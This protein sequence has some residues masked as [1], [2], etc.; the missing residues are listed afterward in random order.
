MQALFISHGSPAL[1][2]SEHPARDF[3][4][5]LG[6]RLPRPKGALVISAHFETPS[7]TLGAAEQPE[8][9]H[10]F[11]GF[12]EALYQVRYPAP[13]LPT[14]AQQLA[15]TLRKRG[16]TTDLDPDRPLDHGVWS[17]LSLLWPDAK[18]PL[19]PISV[20]MALTTEEQLAVAG[21]LGDFAEREELWLVGS[22]AAT[23]N[24]GDRKPEN[25]VPDDWAREFHDWARDVAVRGD[26]ASLADWQRQ[27][28]HARHAHPTAEHFLPLLMTVGALRG[29]PMSA[30][31]ESFSFGNL[32]MLTLASPSLAPHWQ[33]AA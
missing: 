31:H 21:E 30:L 28:P 7:L 6:T 9:L 17:P 3:L 8:T 23:H 24:L 18:V 2:L 26:L 13:G 22:G 1:L 32:S 27:A 5:T 10:D 14:A 11:Y 4:A 15:E 29:T 16:W 33:S 12:P 20:P 19:L 25:S